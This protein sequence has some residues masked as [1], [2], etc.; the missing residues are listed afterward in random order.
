MTVASPHPLPFSDAIR[1]TL[2]AAYRLA[3]QLTESQQQAEECLVEAAM[4]GSRVRPYI[5]PGTQVD[6]WFMGLVVRSCGERSRRWEAPKRADDVDM[7]ALPLYGSARG[8][9]GPS[10][11]KDRAERLMASLPAAEIT[12]AL[13]SLP[14]EH[15]VIAALYY[16]TQ[17]SYG[18]LARA[19]ETTRDELRPR[20]HRARRAL[21]VALAI[22]VGLS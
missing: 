10:S 12:A 6:P 21:Q 13:R 16:V 17:W 7:E 8:G 2:G 4:L 22:S 5:E 14:W 9:S 19:L 18:D 1:P 11:E 20:L 15:R 3:E